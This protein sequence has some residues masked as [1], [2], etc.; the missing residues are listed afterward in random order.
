MLRISATPVDPQDGALLAEQILSVTRG[1]F[2]FEVPED[3]S[4]QAFHDRFLLRV[5]VQPV[6]DA[7]FAALLADPVVQRRAEMLTRR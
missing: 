4:L 6:G 3:E 2:E 1:T 5:P 7:S